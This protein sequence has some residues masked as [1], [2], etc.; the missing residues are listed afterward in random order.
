[1]TGDLLS[2]C[3]D[4]EHLRACISS[5]TL[6]KSLTPRRDPFSA[7]SAAR[8]SI[9]GLSLRSV[10][11]LKLSLGSEVFHCS[12]YQVFPFV[13]H[14]FKEFFHRSIS[15]LVFFLSFLLGSG[16]FSLNGLSVFLLSFSA[17]LGDFSLTPKTTIQISV[18]P[19]L[20]LRLLKNTCHHLHAQGRLHPRREA[21]VM[22]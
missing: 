15:C 6:R 11:F 18:L 21:I 19:F 8:P 4:K 5:S 7:P 22:T 13:Y 14:L 12:T 16:G 2:W 20:S 10:F 9:N 3:N 1:M 17:E